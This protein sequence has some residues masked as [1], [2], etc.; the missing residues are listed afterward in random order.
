M[1]I[2]KKWFKEELRRLSDRLCDVEKQ[3][4]C[5]HN[6]KDWF[7]VPPS[8]VGE[9]GYYVGKCKDCNF[10]KRYSIEDGKKIIKKYHEQKLK[11]INET[12]G[13]DDG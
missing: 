2:S 4:S 12:I 7:E 10:E 5:S 3:I 6:F 13:E 11:E 9:K 8:Y 1:F